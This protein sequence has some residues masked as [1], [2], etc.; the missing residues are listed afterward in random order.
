MMLKSVIQPNQIEIRF[1]FWK[2]SCLILS[3]IERYSLRNDIGT[4]SAVPDTA[5]K[6]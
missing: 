4:F 3:V 2:I 1:E 6:S 5:M